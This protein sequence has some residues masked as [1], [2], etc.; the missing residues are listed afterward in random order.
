MTV[1]EAAEVLRKGGV[2]VI[3]TETV[4]G[5]A[6]NALDPHAVRRIFDLKGRP[7]Q[8][9]LIVHLAEL[10]H[11][12]TVAEIPRVPWLQPLLEAFWP[13]PLSVVLPKRTVVP[14]ITSGGLDTVAVRVPNHPLALELLQQLDFPLAAPSANLY[15]EL[16]PT[17]VGQ[18]SPTI[19]ERADFVLDGGPCAVGI[20]STVV[21]ATREIPVILRPGMISAVDIAEVAGIEPAT[22]LSSIK[23]PGH[24]DRHYSPITPLVLV[25]EIPPGT[26]ALAL[27]PNESPTEYAK[28][29]YRDLY[30][31]DQARSEAIYVQKPPQT[32]AWSAIWDR[33]RRAATR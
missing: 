2:G 25:D 20:E 11:V 16:S 27:E 4:Y 26:A 13:G 10:E 29:L 5:L 9:P 15:G 31:L 14:D 1:I 21:D 32:E 8:N 30:R 17:S 24:A 19:A 3:P 33:L 22:E 12:K 23:S 18:L 6:G 7:R 28:R